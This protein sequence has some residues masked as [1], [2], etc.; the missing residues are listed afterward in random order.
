MSNTTV[1]PKKSKARK[2]I[3]QLWSDLYSGVSFDGF[4]YIFEVKGF[5]R[6]F[7]L[8]IVLAATFLGVFLFYGVMVEFLTYK[9]TQNSEEVKG[10]RVEFPTV[11]ICNLNSLSKSKFLRNTMGLTLDDVLDFYQEVKDGEFNAND[12]ADVKV[13]NRLYEKNI[14][15]LRDILT[16]Y[17]YTMEEMLQDDH[18]LSIVPRPCLFKNVDCTRDDFIEIISAKYGLCYQF[19]SIY[20]EKNRLFV[21]KAGEGEGLRLFVNIPDEDLMISTEPFTGLQVFIHPFG[22]PFESVIAKRI[23]IPP[24]KMDFIYTELYKV[25]YLIDVD[26]IVYISNFSKKRLIKCYHI[27][28]FIT[29]GYTRNEK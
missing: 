3:K 21:H 19:N 14:T 4:H 6:L 9:V 8:V 29:T 16:L 24:G 13:M 1:M 28:A 11:T 20:S 15:E 12:A 25:V 5:L 7:W 10:S 27:L 17:E 22:E 18:L 23:P 2:K 26:L